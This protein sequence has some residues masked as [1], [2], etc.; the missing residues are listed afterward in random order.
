[1]TTELIGPEAL[2]KLR[3]IVASIDV[4][5][6]TTKGEGAPFHSRPMSSNG[7][8]D[9]DGTVWFFTRGESR[10]VDEL[11]EHSDVHVSFACPEKNQYVS[12][13][14]TA[15]IVTDRSTIEKH[16]KPQLKAW[17]PKGMDE[18]GI[19]LVRVLMTEGEYWDANESFISHAMSFAGSLIQ[20][21]RADIGEHG[22]AMR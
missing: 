15:E 18:P 19:T 20:G 14:G 22:K 11:R 13:C 3:E 8:I 5:M 12:V 9:E 2:R 4:G 17:F 6:M 1:M 16:W 10:L 7:D 21:T